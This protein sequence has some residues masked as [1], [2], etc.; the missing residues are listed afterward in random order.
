MR[1]LIQEQEKTFFYSQE[2]DMMVTGK[3]EARK[4]GEGIPDTTEDKLILQKVSD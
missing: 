4:R 3:L 1:Y 2:F